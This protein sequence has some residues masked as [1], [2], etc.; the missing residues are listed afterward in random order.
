[1]S[2]ARKG[3]G[4]QPGATD[5]RRKHGK[6]KFQAMQDHVDGLLAQGAQ[7][8]TIVDGLKSSLGLTESDATAM[9]SINVNAS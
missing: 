7:P 6:K 1:V 8:N 9:I 3:R 5:L 2:G 4:K